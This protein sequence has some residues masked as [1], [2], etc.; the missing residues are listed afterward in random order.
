MMPQ[1]LHRTRDLAPPV[2]DDT[3][4]VSASGLHKTYDTGSVHV[5]ALSGVDLA[6]RRGEMVQASFLVESLLVTLVG[7]VVGSRLGLWVAER[8]CSTPS[9]GLA[10][11]LPPGSGTGASSRSLKPRTERWASITDAGRAALAEDARLGAR[12]REVLERLGAAGEMAAA[13][14]AAETSVLKRLEDRG[15]LARED[16]EV[17]RRPALE[18]RPL[19]QLVADRLPG[20]AE[21]AHQLAVQEPGIGTRVLAEEGAGQLRRPRLPTMAGED[22][23]RVVRHREPQVHPDVDDH[24]HGP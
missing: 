22:A 24:P 7:V 15:L 20:D 19:A 5:N 14:A 3:T 12:Q 17:R 9:R 10:L 4:I 2:I 16:R 13:D 1:Y 11:V 23:L 18:P 6:L 8:Y 21:V